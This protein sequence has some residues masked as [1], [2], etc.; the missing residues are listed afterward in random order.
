MKRRQSKSTRNFRTVKNVFQFS[1]AAA[2]PKKKRKK[3]KL[4]SPTP[5]ILTRSICVCLGALFPYFLC[6]PL[7]NLCTKNPTNK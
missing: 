4:F 6:Y 7:Y 3:E 5:K 1:A 2:A